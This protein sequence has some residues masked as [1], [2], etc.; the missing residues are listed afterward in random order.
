MEVIIKGLDFECDGVTLM[1]RDVIKISAHPCMYTKKYIIEKIL[2]AQKTGELKREYISPDFWETCHICESREEV[3]NAEYG[4]VDM[5]TLTFCDDSLLFCKGNGA[6]MVDMIE[7]RLKPT[8]DE[9]INIYFEQYIQLKYNPVLE[10]NEFFDAVLILPDIHSLRGYGIVLAGDYITADAFIKYSR[11][12]DPNIYYSYVIHKSALSYPILNIN[13]PSE[14][15]PHLIGKGGKR[16]TEFRNL[17]RDFPGSKVRRI[18]L[19]HHP[20]VL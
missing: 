8:T 16:I 10:Q 5:K 3:L 1:F 20:A 13:A 2:E 19:I 6:Y 9:D 17:L 4:L 14:L 18:N 7:I 11:Y 12:S 15:I